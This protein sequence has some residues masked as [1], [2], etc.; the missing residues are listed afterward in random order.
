ME[1]ADAGQFLLA[2][3]DMIQPGSHKLGGTLRFQS[4]SDA[5]CEAPQEV[6]FELPLTILAGIPPAPQATG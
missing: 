3:G 1:P 5:I 2:L 6:R 4:C